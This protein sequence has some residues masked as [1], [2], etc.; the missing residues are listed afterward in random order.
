MNNFKI[1]VAVE[2]GD[3]NTTQRLILQHN[4][5]PSLYAV[6]MGIINGN[7]NT[8]NFAMS[9]CFNTLR[10]ETNI[11]SIHYNYKTQSWNECIPKEHQY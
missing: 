7:H 9:H 11:K 5:C 6:Q 3:M 10:S 4:V 2:T 1:D 8:A